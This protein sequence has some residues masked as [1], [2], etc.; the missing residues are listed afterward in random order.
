MVFPIYNIHI[1][2]GRKTREA[3][4][5]RTRVANR[6]PGGEQGMVVGAKKKREPSEQ[7]AQ[8]P[9]IQAVLKEYSRYWICGL[10][11]PGC[12]LRR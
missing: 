6:T 12:A 11:A 10:P 3:K 4:R 7:H 2:K 1:D 8:G 9:Q 5:G